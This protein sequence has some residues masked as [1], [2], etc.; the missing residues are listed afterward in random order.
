[1]VLGGA[2]F[3]E[4]VGGEEGTKIGF[5]EGEL[6]APFYPFSQYKSQLSSENKMGLKN[7]GKA[8]FITY[9]NQSQ[10]T[11]G[12]SLAGVKGGLRIKMD[13]TKK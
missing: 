1:M 7:W 13:K 6:Y 2:W 10:D 4:E 5:R 8:M 11:A 3:W 9:N 12:K